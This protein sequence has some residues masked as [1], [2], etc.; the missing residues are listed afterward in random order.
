[1]VEILRDRYGLPDASPF[2][3]IPSLSPDLNICCEPAAF[4]TEAERKSFEPVAFYGCLPASADG[5]ELAP[6]P[7]GASFSDGPGEFKIY[8]CFGTV[9]FQYYADVAIRVL[10]ALSD[11][12]AD[13][14]EARALISLGGATVDDGV[15]RKL[16]KPNVEA[17]G[18]AD[19][20][21]ALGETD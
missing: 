11:C 5:R 2:S 13:M 18:Y 20:W 12:V 15:L 21:G 10:E 9:A 4:L 14:P 8:A 7:A 17:V 6:D 19:Q 16:R 1:A 3:Y